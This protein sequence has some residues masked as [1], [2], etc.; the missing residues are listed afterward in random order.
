M[1]VFVVNDP[2]PRVQGVSYW[3]KKACYAKGFVRLTFLISM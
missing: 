3:L 2:L 1:P